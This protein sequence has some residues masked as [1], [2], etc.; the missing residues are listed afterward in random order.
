MTYAIY[1]QII[2]IKL[3]FQ[4]A[5]RVSDTQDKVIS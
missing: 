2:E 5:R 1:L 4:S 3:Y